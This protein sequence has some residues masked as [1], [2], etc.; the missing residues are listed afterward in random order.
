MAEDIK[1]LELRIRELENQLKQQQAA[2]TPQDL[3]KEEIAAY[4]KVSSA[5][6]AAA[7]D[8]DCGINECTPIKFCACRVCQICKVCRTCVCINECVCGPCNICRIGGG[9]GGFSGFGG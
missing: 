6:N 9:G 3:T 1:K 5:L 8:W 2:A 7:G 4:H